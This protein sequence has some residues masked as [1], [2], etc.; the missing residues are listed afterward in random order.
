MAADPSILS[1]SVLAA[2][3]AVGLAGIG[4]GIGMGISTSKAFEG[5]A[6]Q[7]DAEPQIARN[8]ILAMAFMEA[9]AIYGLVVAL[10]LLFA[11]PFK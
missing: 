1:S 5:M 6:R 10:I 3:A 11:N 2:G 8:M 9:I 7:P 4:A